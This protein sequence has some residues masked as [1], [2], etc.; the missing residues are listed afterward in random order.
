MKLKYRLQPVV[1]VRDRAKK[2]AARIVAV[3]REQL[4]NAEAQLRRCEQAVEDCR[5]QQAEVRA[6]MLDE[7]TLGTEVRRMVEY[8]THL[9]DLNNKE[10]ELI[11]EVERQHIVVKR[12][13]AELENAL[14]VLVESSK[15]LKV[16]EKHR[17]QWRERERQQTEKREQKLNDE[18]GAILYERSERRSS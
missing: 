8:R 11:A 16:I 9:K 17:E 15:E 4:A 13:E 14:A 2:E 6:R 10:K 18:I 5:A 3:R 1:D 12:A 7:A